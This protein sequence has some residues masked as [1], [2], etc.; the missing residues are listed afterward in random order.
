MCAIS[1]TLP[2]IMAENI[3]QRCLSAF[4]ETQAIYLFGSWGTPAERGESDVDLALLLPCQQAKA[5][6]SLYMTPLHHQ[7]EAMLLRDVDLIN[8]RQVSTVLQKEIIAEDRRAY[9]ADSYA[10]DEFEM[11]TISYYQ[12]LNDERADV[13]ESF[14]KSKRAYNV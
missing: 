14:F 2:N 7:L 1:P 5:L 12:K 9:C 13:L 4:P 8:L 6:K 3:V 11:L 10:A